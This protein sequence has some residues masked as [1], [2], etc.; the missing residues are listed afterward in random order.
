M[1]KIVLP[2]TPRTKKNSQQ[3]FYKKING[4]QIPF[5]SP[6]KLYKEFE[7]ECW[8]YLFDYSNLL[9][10]YPV[11]VKCTFYMQSRRKVDLCNLEEAVCDVLV[12]YHVVSDDNRDIIASHD[13]SRVYYDKENPRIEIEIT[14]LENYTQWKE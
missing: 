3:I 10:D 13:G 14:K 5:I 7:K 11:N 9:I 12:K 8:K 6:S 1:I 2:V 4:K